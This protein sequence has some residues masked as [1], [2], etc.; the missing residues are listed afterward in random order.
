MAFYL[1]F[2]KGHFNWKKET[3]FMCTCNKLIFLTAV[4]PALDGPALE[5]KTVLIGEQS[6][7]QLVCNITGNSGNISWTFQGNPIS[8]SDSRYVIDETSTILSFAGAVGYSDE[9]K[10]YTCTGTN[11]AGSTTK[12]Y[13]IIVLGK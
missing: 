12:T 7:F 1:L 2:K 10:K 4:P 5:N 13:Q 11:S 9:G 8:P 3:K 6:T